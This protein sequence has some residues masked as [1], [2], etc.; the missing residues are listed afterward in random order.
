MTKIVLNKQSLTL[1]PAQLIQSG[2]E[3]M[4]FA[5]G[6]TAVKLYHQPQPHHLAKL[7][8]FLDTGLAAQLPTAVIGPT[9]LVH[10]GRHQVIGFQMP[11][12]P[13]DT[14]PFKQFANPN[15]WQKNSVDG[16]AVVALLIHAHQTLQ[17]L[18]QLGVVVGDLNDT[19]V[20]FHLPSQTTAWIDVDS[21]Q[22]GAFPCPVAAQAF[23]DPQLY[24]V[25]DFS[26]KP[27]FTPLTD[28]YAYLVLLVKSLLQVHPYGGIH[29]QYK[30]ME[31]RAQ[32]KMS[33][34]ETA[35]TYPQRACPPETLSDD[36]LQ[37]LHRVFTQGE[38]VPF[39]VDLLTQ[40]AASLHTCGQC[41]LVYPQQ[42]RDCPACRQIT[43]VAL[44]IAA[45]SS[46]LREILRVDGFIE[47]VRVRPDGRIWVIV[48][49]ADSYKLIRLGIGG[50]LDEMV[51]F[52]GRAGYR[53]AVFG[54]AVVVNPP[55]G[56][57]LLILDV[58]GTQPRRLTLV[59]TA[60]FRDTAVFA[61]TPQS[62]YR[63]AGGW[64]M[65]GRV[66]DGQYLEE[67]VATAHQAQTLFFGSPVGDGIVG[68]HRV[69]AEYRFFFLDERHTNYDLIVPP[70]K[71]GESVTE[72]AVAFGS[73]SLALQLT[74]NHQGQTRQDT[75]LFTLQGK[76]LQ[77]FS[78]TNATICALHYPFTTR[79]GLPGPFIQ[80]PPTLSIDEATP[81]HQ[82]RSGWL[83]QYPSHLEFM[84]H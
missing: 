36:L 19:N 1:D 16:R 32:A 41:G 5:V 83:V 23:L 47:A 45:G 40:Y 8:H 72:T 80:L 17:K 31:A 61:A 59:E 24:G 7:R 30:T 79:P 37:H 71:L 55:N 49:T 38:R 3:G 18:H 75:H 77:R 34:L 14:V 74:I 44:P 11:K 57:Q 21:Y 65:R 63:I 58:S 60:T 2:G 12:L 78:E 35:V 20:F 26:H 56:R 4:V 68:Y 27:V 6:D 48:R 52:N 42:R 53:C 22:V 50:K 67:P 84:A 46:G 10:N 51:L 54:D 29:G 66:Q 82:H 33:V 76:P 9:T 39:P 81:V 28:W 43:P 62:L 25:A 70:L 69:F 64:M 73:T 13:P 15:Y